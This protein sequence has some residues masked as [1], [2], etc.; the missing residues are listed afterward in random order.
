MDTVTPIATTTDSGNEA[1]SWVGLAD[2]NKK[3]I[4]FDDTDLAGGTRLTEA[5]PGVADEIR[6]KAA[7]SRPSLTGRGKRSPQLRLSIPAEL[8]QQFG[9]APNASTP[10][11][12]TSPAKPSNATSPHSWAHPSVAV[13][14]CRLCE[15]R[16]VCG[17]RQTLMGPARPAV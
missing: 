12:P 11:C 15:T 10:P 17:S 13:Q 1:L 16:S 2:R 14:S 6:Q 4:R 8:R 7:R 5:Y 9:L 3:T